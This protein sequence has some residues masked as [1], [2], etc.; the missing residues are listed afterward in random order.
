MHFLEKAHIISPTLFFNLSLHML[1]ETAV[2]YR[3]FIQTPCFFPHF[4]GEGVYILFL[5]RDHLPVVPYFLSNVT[6]PFQTFV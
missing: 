4:F 2:W 5:S 3:E 1:I 6:H